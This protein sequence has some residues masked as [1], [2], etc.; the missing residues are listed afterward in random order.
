[1]GS[2]SIGK[3]HGGD[4]VDI[5]VV[6]V[7]ETLFADIAGGKDPEVAVISEKEHRDSHI[8]TSADMAGDMERAEVTAMRGDQIVVFRTLK[9]SA[10]ADHGI[11]QGADVVVVEGTFPLV[12]LDEE[13]AAVADDEPLL[14]TIAIGCMFGDAPLVAEFH[15]QAGAEVQSPKRGGRGAGPRRWILSGSG[16]GLG[17]LSRSGGGRWPSLRSGSFLKG[18]AGEKGAEVGGLFRGILNQDAVRGAFELGA[19]AATG[20]MAKLSVGVDDGVFGAHR[21]GAVD[22][23]AAKGTEK[24][25]REGGAVLPGQRSGELVGASGG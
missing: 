3:A 5:G 25:V 1:M 10:A 7:L 6:K 15:N 24:Q 9:D 8:F 21:A 12:A 23:P 19:L 14:E 20:D 16:L 13:V 17:S 22:G 2:L 4:Q 18:P 11:D